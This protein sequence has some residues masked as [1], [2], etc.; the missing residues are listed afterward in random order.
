MFALAID[1]D[2][3]RALD[4]ARSNVTRQREPLDLLVLSQAARASGDPAALR[5]ARR[6]TNEMGLVDQRIKAIQ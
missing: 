1:R 5:E 3:H 2:A 6:L 4:L